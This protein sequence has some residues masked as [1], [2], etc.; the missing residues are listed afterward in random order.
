MW[1]AIRSLGAERI[2]HGVRAIEDARLVTHLAGTTIALDVCPRSN[3]CLGVYPKL[4][5]HPLP[6][7]IRAG[8]AVTINSDD[9][10]MFGTSLSDEAV[11]LA[12]PFGMDVETVD[13]IILNGIRHSF[14]SEERK[15]GFLTEFQ[16][17]MDAL[18]AIHLGT[19][20]G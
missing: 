3:V 1:G 8:V 10:P 11:T 5:D 19:E 12:D 13:G 17:E 2:A 7:L 9:P 15:A 20:T 6:R 16:R 4:E 14:L 18:K